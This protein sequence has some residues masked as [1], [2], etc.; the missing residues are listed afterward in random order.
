MMSHKTIIRTKHPNQQLE[1]ITP[2][3][4]YNQHAENQRYVQP[5]KRVCP[6]LFTRSYRD[7]LSSNLPILALCP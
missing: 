4:N 3:N 2:T 1:P 6:V 5:K 7:N